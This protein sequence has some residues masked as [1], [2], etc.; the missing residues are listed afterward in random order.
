MAAPNQCRDVTGIQDGAYRQLRRWG[1]RPSLLALAFL[2]GL[3][4]IL[5][6][7]SATPWGKA[8][9]TAV[10]PSVHRGVALTPAFDPFPSAS[11][12]PDLTLGTAAN[13][14]EIC[15][16]STSTCSA[17]TG[18]AR[19]TLSAQATS[20]PRPYW[21]DVQVAFVIETTA[22][23]GVADHYNA[24][25]GTDPCAV[26]TSDQGP[27]CEESNGVPFFVANAGVLAHAIA[28]ENPH[29]NV[30]FAMVDFFGTD[31]DWN[32]G[33]FD[34]WKYHV[35]IADFVPAADFGG[36]VV[37]SFQAEQL[38]EGNGWGCVCGLDDNF[39]HSSSITALYGTIIGSGLTWS[40][41]THHVIVLM[42]SAAP[43][44]PSYPEN[45]WVSGFDQCCTS[46]TEYS[47]TCEPAYVFSN[48]A[49]PNCEGWV[50][51]QDGNPTHS[52]AALTKTS[53]TCTESI[54]GS[55]TV[56][57]IDYWD[58][59][60]DPYS[61]GWPV[62]H[63]VVH[64]SGLPV[65]S[66]GPGG[67]AVIADSVNILR[68]GCDLAA[69]TGGNWNGPAY[70]TCPDG[71]SGSLQYVSHGAIDNPTTYNPTL[72]SALKQISFGPV[73]A[74]LVANGSSHPIFTYVPPANFAV[75]ADPQYATAC[76]T[77][78]GYLTTCQVVPTVLHQNGVT[79]L[80][81]NWSTNKSRNQLYVGD[82]WTASFNVVNT[83][84]PDSLD[85]VLA[86]T[87]VTCRAAGSGAI[88]GLFSSASYFPPNSTVLQSLSFPLAQVKVI[89]E[90]VG[91]PP[92]LIPPPSPPIPPAFPIVIAPVTPVLIA[93]PTAVGQG[94][95]TVSLQAAAAGFLGAGFMRV[96]LKNRPIAMKV[97]AKTGPQVSR[98]DAE[99]NRKDTNVGRFV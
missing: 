2:V 46:P 30:S 65:G 21:P 11:T 98:F 10:A 5:I 39:L 35:D 37:S 68:A 54:G 26:A 51:S 75:A 89:G 49:S 70:W 99:K 88:S 13:P 29:S 1:R 52:I 62:G 31:Y 60:T 50:R 73:Y 72:F 96:S 80:G 82:A 42:G 85:P 32:D 33:P 81:W 56:D 14:A 24:F 93:T 91:A 57:V 69:A 43:R 40:L 38:N 59:P 83:G 8:P 36:Q 64:P 34:S 94:I 76:V 19:V 97:A 4:T 47:G 41:A 28:G 67:T 16:V 15:A 48:S 86:C 9:G 74:S 61:Q 84:P 79:F 6:A 20:S 87:T 45:Y 53:P 23:D 25:E 18:V 71:Q 63:N 95:G 27:L 22:Y 12:L 3:L 78:N 44:D 58:T 77:P 92:P 7:G 55:C 17:G 90:V 66:S